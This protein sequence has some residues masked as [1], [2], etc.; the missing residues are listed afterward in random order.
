MYSKE[1]FESKENQKRKH[2]QKRK[3][4]VKKTEG[5][6]KK[7]EQNKDCEGFAQQEGGFVGVSPQIT[8][9]FFIVI[10]VFRHEDAN[11]NTVHEWVNAAPLLL[12]SLLGKG[13]KQ[14]LGQ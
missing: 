14:S 8:L 11:Q 7:K 4:K 6:K 10:N 1:R 5:G 3:V 13:W 9:T 12:I 2:R